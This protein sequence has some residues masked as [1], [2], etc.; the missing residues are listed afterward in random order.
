[1][2]SQPEPL[3]SFDQDPMTSDNVR[4]TLDTTIAAVGS[5]ATN[6]GAGTSI[7]AWVL[8]SEFGMLAGLILAAAGFLVNWYYKHKEDKRQQLEHER[9]MMGP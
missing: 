4:A 9:R 5:K 3:S 2:N 7:V 8:S 6:V 1:M